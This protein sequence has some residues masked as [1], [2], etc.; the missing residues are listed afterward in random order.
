MPR[1][2]HAASGAEGCLRSSG[3]HAML[4]PDEGFGPRSHWHQSIAL[5]RGPP[6]GCADVAASVSDAGSR[7]PALNEGSEVMLPLDSGFGPK[8]LVLG[9]WAFPDRALPQEMC[10]WSHGA[11]YAARVRYES[12]EKDFRNVQQR[13]RD[14]NAAD[15]G[16]RLPPRATSAC[17]P[18]EYGNATW[19][20]ACRLGS[21]VAS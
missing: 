17:P 12:S 7:C 14:H 13:G 20:P 10:V 21:I 11:T 8:W 9:P 16:E 19:S 6:H 4:S 15:T 1:L 2:G 18:I 5:V 3:L